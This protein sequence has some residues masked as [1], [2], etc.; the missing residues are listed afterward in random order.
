MQP[1]QELLPDALFLVIWHYSERKS[2][3]SNG[4]GPPKRALGSGVAGSV[5]LLCGVG[6]FSVSPRESRGGISG[7]V[8]SQLP[9]LCNQ[10]CS[11]SCSHMGTEGMEDAAEGTL[12]SALVRP[13]LQYCVQLWNLQYKKDRD[14]VE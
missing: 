11:S 6:A 8:C 7:C 9:W 14:L 12:F 13:Y 4:A 5:V 2:T 1:T 10:P 3:D